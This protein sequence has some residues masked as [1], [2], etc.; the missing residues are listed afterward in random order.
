MSESLKNALRNLNLVVGAMMVLSVIA[1]A[2]FADHIAPYAF[3]E[4][5][6]EATYS[7]PDDVYIF[8]T[9]DFGR[10]MF[11]R[12]V[13]GS[14]ITLKVAL[15]AVIIQSVIGVSAGLIG[16]YYGGRIDAGIAFVT[17][18]TW[19]MPPLITALA[20]IT[21]LGKGLNNIIAAQ[22]LVCWAQY[23]RI[24]R[25]KTQA[26]KNMPFIETGIAFGERNSAIML[27]YILPNI[28]PSIIVIAT[29]SI[30]TTIMSTTSLGFLGMGSQ[31][32]SPDW[33]VMLSV[34]IKH[35]SKAPWMAIYP[36]LAL[37]YTVLGFSLVGEGL[38]DLLDPRMKAQ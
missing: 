33:G 19:A 9:D 31:P 29:I 1:F 18:I 35:L 20:V 3:D 24:V 12:V 5:H 6:L 25:A 36:G 16:G 21:V 27:R 8:G 4:A 13:Y 37:V 30:P 26:I 11:S 15:I 32:P 23:A 17:D 7:A 22:A 2:L 38:R 28:L 14:R 10:D 34:S